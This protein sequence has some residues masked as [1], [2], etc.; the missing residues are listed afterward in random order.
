[1]FVYI[2]NKRFENFQGSKETIWRTLNT[3]FNR[4]TEILSNI[5]KFWY[6]SGIAFISN[7]QLIENIYLSQEEESSLY[8]FD[9]EKNN[10]FLLLNNF[11]GPEGYMHS[12]KGLTQ[13]DIENAF[14]IK[15]DNAILEKIGGFPSRLKLHAPA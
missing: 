14:N 1:M 8:Q 3:P 9:E 11:A 12:W 2:N 15:F 6:P 5:N 4:F 13:S 7:K 10:R